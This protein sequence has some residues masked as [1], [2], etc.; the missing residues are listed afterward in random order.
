MTDYWLSKLLFDLQSTPALMA[1]YKKDR[2]A[3][4]ARYTL[5]AE[6]Q[7]ALLADEVVFIAPRVNPYLLRFYFSA[8]GMKDAD[9]IAKLRTLR[10]AAPKE[11][12]RKEAAHG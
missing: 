7:A 4:M 3:V 2:K 5:S 11:T 6:A 1:E 9:L 8:T 12:P 10:E